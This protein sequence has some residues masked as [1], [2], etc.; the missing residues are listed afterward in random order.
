MS[1]A[2]SDAPL[3]SAEMTSPALR[4]R[5]PASFSGNESQTSQRTSTRI[6]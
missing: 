3:N 4:T 5:K 6:V 1:T 2:S